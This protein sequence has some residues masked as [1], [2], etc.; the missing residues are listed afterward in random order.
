MSNFSYIT[1]PLDQFEIRNLLNLDAPLLGNLHISLTNT[2]L[3][4]CVGSFSIITLNLLVFAG[5]ILDNINPFII[6]VQSASEATQEQINEKKAALEQAYNDRADLVKERKLIDEAHSTAGDNNLDTEADL[7]DQLE[8]IDE[9][10]IE[11]TQLI[12]DIISWLGS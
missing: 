5:G 6:L 11:T 7:G 1:S 4:I 12:A 10:I 2:G 9:L 8:S 3:Y